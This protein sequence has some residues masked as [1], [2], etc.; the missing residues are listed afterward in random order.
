[1]YLQFALAALLALTGL[2]GPTPRTQGPPAS[3]D[4]VAGRTV[5]NRAASTAADPATIEKL[6]IVVPHVEASGKVAAPASAGGSAGGAVVADQLVAPQRLESKVMEVKDFQTVGV[7]WPK[8][9]DVGALG[10]EVRTRNGGTWS[11]WVGLKP[12]DDAP[13]AGTSDAA[14]AVRGGTDP[15][16]VGGADAVQLA[17][18]A[19]AKGGPEGLSLALVDSA[20]KPAAD[21]VVDSSS[22]TA[23][24]RT[25]AYSTNA[26]TVRT[27]AYS[28]G[29]AAVAGAPHVISRAE[30][31]AAAPACA[32]DVA[33]ALVGAV[34]HHSA[35][36]NGY[37][38]V[39]EAEA[40]I[41]GDQAYH[42]SGRGW[43]DIGY[44]FIVDKWGNIYEGRVNSLTQA[45]IGVHAGGFNTGTVG[46]A[47][48]GTFDALPS[49]ATQDSVGWIIGW[50]LGAS[51]VDPQGS[52]TY[53]T[54]AGD[55]SR[56]LNENVVL[57]RIF[58]HRD[59]SFT[60]CPGD[61]G[62]AA[63]GTIR[64]AAAAAARAFNR[65]PIG[66]VDRIS[67]GTTT[68]NA[69]GWALDPDTANPITVHVYID[70]VPNPVLADVARPD[71]GAAF[72]DGDQHGFNVAIPVSQG[73]HQVCIYAIDTA[74]GAN[75]TLGCASVRVGAV[76]IGN[77]ESGTSVHG[78][79]VVGGWAL[80]PD[81]ADP[82]TVHVYVDGVGTPVLA[83][84]A[85]PD[86]GAAFHD[87]D[88]HGFTAT[89]PASA[90][91]HTVCVYAINF[92][93]GANTTLG[94][95]SVA[96]TNA[97]PIGALDGA[98]G[99]PGNVAVRGW[100][101][102]P[103]T[104]SPIAVHVYVDGT[105]SVLTADVSRPDIA[106]AFGLGDRHGFAATVTASV[107]SH[108]VCAY[109]INTPA[110][111]NPNLGCRTVQVS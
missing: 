3:S 37:A 33:S 85:R 77:F 16:W 48:L 96:V 69:V 52:M 84:G 42:I 21:G 64:A 60:E 91:T 32:A 45:V 67:A 14:R 36:S 53:Y 70:G 39:A 17:F 8:G 40:Q 49:A 74:G 66:A 2:A 57:P 7:T 24:A 93:S 81:T 99:G 19:T 58:A 13:D 95:R 83:D 38:S 26:A 47:M 89:L 54:G 94:C 18:A 102:D 31:G 108:Q 86:V 71:V 82:I 105:P 51:Y 11:S 97:A 101:L 92:P 87:G 27:A 61:G 106:A 111:D 9:S 28:T 100:A 72:H 76:P 63:M 12:A 10:A 109:A 78:A 73:D 88:R 98:T 6:D 56:F 46:V 15:V 110:G 22:G 43:C 68:I 62:Y 30:W 35:G 29:V 20:T 50:R 41:R 80:D 44:N 90:G 23:T 65:A 104:A 1:M 107:G 4:R 79:L 55:D 75:P 34:V 5:A 103:D 25:A 59:V